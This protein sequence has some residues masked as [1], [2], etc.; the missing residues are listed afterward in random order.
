[1][2]YNNLVYLLALQKKDLRNALEM[3][4]QAI[5]VLGPSPQLRDTRALVLMAVWGPGVL[6]A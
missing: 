4:D 6:T 3:I 1:M 5:S 2:V